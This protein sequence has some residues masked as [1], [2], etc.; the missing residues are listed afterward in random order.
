MIEFL[1]FCVAGSVL[2]IVAG[3]VPGLHVNNMVPFVMGL[4][5]L[6]GDPHSLAVLVVSMAVSQV[7]ASFI[8]SIFVGAPEADTSLSSLP[9]HRMLQ[10]GRGLEAMRLTVIGG[11]CSLAISFLLIYFLSPHFRPFYDISRPYIQ[12][13]LLGVIV[14]MVVSE[15]KMPRILSASCIVLM[16]GLLGFIALNSPLSNQNSV[17]FPLLTGLF[18]IS[19][20]VSSAVGGSNISDQSSDGSFRSR[21]IDLIKSIVLGSV[22]GLVVG[23]LPAVGVSQAATIFQQI[24]GLNDAR[25]F[26][27]SLSGINVA[28]EVFS[29]NSVYLIDN[30]RSGASV[31]VERILGDVTRDDLTLFSSAIAISAGIGAAASLHISRF[32][33]RIISRINYRNLS[34]AVALML[35][36][37]IGL[38]TGPFGLL[39][40]GAAVSVGMLCGRM[41]IRNGN[42]MGVLMVPSLF[43]FS[44]VS[45]DALALL[46]V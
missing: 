19:I 31:A 22:A 26:L 37:M 45:P 40:A 30:P 16:S 25:T 20:L 11:L 8:P 9:G 33:P 13:A 41:G 46:G 23:F 15:R 5:L 27:V 10:E 39:V 2:G 6:V 29:L 35:V 17:L 7:F 42:C 12:Y 28:N 38:M 36:S 14:F 34:I 18:G 3:L 44:G 1:L 21:K 43:F 4:S 24:G 32:I